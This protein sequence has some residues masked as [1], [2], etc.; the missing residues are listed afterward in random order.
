M[1]NFDPTDPSA[2]V[3]MLDKYSDKYI[4]DTYEWL[5]HHAPCKTGQLV[6]V[7]DPDG[8]LYAIGRC[9]GLEWQN[10]M[11]VVDVEIYEHPEIVIRR[12]CGANVI[13]H[14]GPCMRAV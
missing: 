4:N 14:H 10:Y 6:K 13:P 2:Y 11:W 7:F 8:K 1:L 12:Y 9:M 3:K 5:R